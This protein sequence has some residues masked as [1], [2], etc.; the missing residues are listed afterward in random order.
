MRLATLDGSLKNQL[1]MS[2]NRASGLVTAHDSKPPEPS[3]F[4]DRVGHQPSSH[5]GRYACGQL[6]IGKATTAL[7]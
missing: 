3:L 5:R 6:S 1:G 4:G 2:D 7:D